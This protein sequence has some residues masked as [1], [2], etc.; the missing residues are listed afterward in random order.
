MESSG[1]LKEKAAIEKAGTQLTN[2]ELEQVTGGVSYN[3]AAPDTFPDGGTPVP[4][5][6][7]R[8]RN[9]RDPFFPDLDKW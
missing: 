1:N 4:E 3:P 2:D 7:F 6:L 5:D 9:M 8:E